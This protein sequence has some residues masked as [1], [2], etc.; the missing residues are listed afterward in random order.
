MVLNGSEVNSKF[1]ISDFFIVNSFWKLETGYLQASGFH[2]CNKILA[3]L[4]VT[5]EKHIRR[6]LQTAPELRLFFS[7]V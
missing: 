3:R 4:F 5:V 1:R 2:G 6:D 7:E